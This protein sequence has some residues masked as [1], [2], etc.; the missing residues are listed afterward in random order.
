MKAYAN[1]L[2]AQVRFSTHRDLFP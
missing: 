2:G 1:V